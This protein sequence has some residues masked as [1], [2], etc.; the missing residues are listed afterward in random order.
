MIPSSG[1]CHIH[2]DRAGLGVCIECKQ[3][4]CRECTTQFE[5]INRCARC[6]AAKLR[7]TRGFQDRREWTVLNVGLALT[8]FA[9]I[10]GFARLVAWMVHR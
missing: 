4:I 10:A 7:G 8:A 6:L 1:R 5:G 2:P 3:V 9:A